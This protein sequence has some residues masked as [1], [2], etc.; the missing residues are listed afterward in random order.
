MNLSRDMGLCE[1]A[2][3]ASLAISKS[4]SIYRDELV[5]LFHNSCT[6][7]YLST[8]QA[9][10]HELNA[11][12]GELRGPAG[13]HFTSNFGRELETHAVVLAL[14][15]QLPVG[16]LEP[17]LVGRHVA[18]LG[19]LAK[20]ARHNV[21]QLLLQVGRVGGREVR[22]GLV[23]SRDKGVVEEAEGIDKGEERGEVL[24][25]GIGGI[26]GQGRQVDG[27][28]QGD[29]SL[30]LESVGPLGGEDEPVEPPPAGGFDG[31]PLPVRVLLVHL[32]HMNHGAGLTEIVPGLAMGFD[33]VIAGEDEVAGSNRVEGGSVEVL[34]AV[35]H[36]HGLL[37]KKC[38]GDEIR[39]GHNV[40]VVRVA[41]RHSHAGL[42]HDEGAKR[43]DEAVDIAVL[44]HEHGLL[45]YRLADEDWH[46]GVH[47]GKEE[48]KAFLDE[49]SR[50][51]A[52]RRAGSRR[53]LRG[54]SREA[55][56]AVLYTGSETR[57]ALRL[58]QLADD[59]GAGA[60][61]ALLLW[62]GIVSAGELSGRAVPTRVDSVALDFPAMA[63]IA[64]PFY[65]GRHCVC[66]EGYKRCL[67]D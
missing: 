20:I 9:G 5:G 64:G 12:A 33:P 14:A 18:E 31:I 26:I 53:I 61:G 65:G 66:R 58:P 30:S 54:T 42:K 60:L 15:G 28:L 56:D 6:S 3:A 67:V 29:G 11:L 16:R 37:Q 48:L 39:A 19:I 25:Q 50:N 32:E 52:G 13:E 10:T 17:L 63:G 55:S 7:P 38:A 46:V 43:G 57:L 59:L 21:V 2:V 4:F 34:V 27:S 49:L 35:P 45:F 1:S 22:S 41:R 47:V 40:E 44:F 36:A 24:S 8:Y 51:H 62:D 23:P